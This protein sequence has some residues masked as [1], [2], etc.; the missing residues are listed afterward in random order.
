MSTKR[1]R[2][3]V[4]V[5]M[6]IVVVGLGPYLY[7]R[8]AASNRR[9]QVFTSQQA[10]V[11]EFS[12]SLKIVCF[13]IAHGRGATDDNWAEGGAP[14]VRR[15]E[16]I[17]DLL[18]KID[19][20]IVVLNEVDFD[21]TW[22]G[23]V[24]QSELLA[25]LARYPFRMERRNLDFGFVYG[26]WK[27]G[28]AVLSKFPITQTSPAD[29]PVHATWESLLAGAKSGAICEIALD[30]QTKIDLMAVHL[31]HR[32]ELTRVQSARRIVELAQ[33]SDRPMIVAGDFNSTPSGFP[34]SDSTEQNDNA[35]N[36]LLQSKAFKTQPTENPTNSDLTFPSDQPDRVIDWIMIPNYANFDSY[37]VIETKLS[38]HLPVVARIQL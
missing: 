26:S 34:F 10:N 37:K 4:A 18:I 13:N 8:Y 29:L 11:P 24:N 5:V 9:V 25:R 27:F 7:S 36:L 28:N 2:L 30:D 21:S 32:S 12:G 38:D 19:A 35:L 16:E 1:K 3:I 20:D 22:S 15:L 23:S 33:S 17:A 31:E 14:K 6:V